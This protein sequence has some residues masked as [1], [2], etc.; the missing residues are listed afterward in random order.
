MAKSITDC[1]GKTISI[2]DYVQAED[3]TVFQVCGGMISE[4]K[5]YNA[6]TCTIVDVNTYNQFK[7][8]VALDVSDV[9]DCVVWG[10]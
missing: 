9:T 2:G 6:E 7:S 5:L 8:T 1:T 3:G 10:A 4:H